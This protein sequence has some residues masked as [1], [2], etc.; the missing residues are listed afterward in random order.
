MFDIG[1]PPTVDLRFDFSFVVFQNGRGAPRKVVIRTS[2]GH[3]IDRWTLTEPEVERSIVIPP[4]AWT[5]SRI[6]LRFL[7]DQSTSPKKLGLSDDP[8]KLSIKLRRLC[9]HESGIA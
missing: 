7:F 2:R 1:S 9:I 5:G 8:R 6:C 3:Q 4:S